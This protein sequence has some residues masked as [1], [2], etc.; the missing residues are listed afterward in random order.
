MTGLNLKHDACHQVLI[1]IRKIIRSVDVYSKRLRLESGVTAPQLIVL[2]EV[3]HSEK[4]TTTTIAENVSL[5]QST[6]TNILDRLVNRN[7]V[8]RKRYSDDKRMWFIELTNEG[9]AL[10]RNSPSLLQQEF[11]DN[12]S[13]LPEWQQTQMLS[14]LQCIAAMMYAYSEENYNQKQLPSD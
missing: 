6:V 8:I 10:A 11:I 3:L 5:S 2:K 13:S 1:A 7:L 4:I 12:F 14:T 9:E